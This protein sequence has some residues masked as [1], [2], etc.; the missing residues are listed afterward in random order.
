[1]T[2]RELRY[3]VALADIG[4]FGR[5]AQ[6]CHV[7]Q[8]TLSTQLRKLEDS[9]GVALFERTNKTLRITPI[10]EQIV[11]KARWVLD[12]ADSIASLARRRSRPLT[13]PFDLGIIPTLGPYM[14]PWLLPPL[15]RAYPD[16]ELVVHE[17][18]TERLLDQIKAHRLDAALMA[19][20]ID[21]G[22]LNALPIF[23]E[24]FRLVLPPGHRLVGAT[25]VNQSELSREH[26]L[27]LREGH[28]LRDQ[29]LEVCSFDSPPRRGSEHRHPRFQPGD[30]LPDGGSRNGLHA[31]ARHGA[32]RGRAARLRGVPSRCGSVPACRSRLEAELPAND[33]S[34]V[35]RA[36]DSGQSSVVGSCGLSEFR[37]FRT[38]GEASPHVAL[39]Q[40]KS[41]DRRS[42][43]NP[44]QFSFSI[45]LI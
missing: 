31:A 32:R 29:A 6:A 2:L 18:L 5:A 45:V 21:D 9:L 14:L 1:M 19:L 35:S 7:S 39:R 10:G 42:D 26:L 40:S 41:V 16:L 20:P 25:G 3:L 28:C 17:D 37:H 13:G 36:G 33:G 24:P 23:D 11:A 4:H 22:E 38:M 44:E 12:E 30:D 27:L 8:P 43:S 34:G 15:E